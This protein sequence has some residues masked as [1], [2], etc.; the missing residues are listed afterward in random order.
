MDLPS[1][2]ICGSLNRTSFAAE[3]RSKRLACDDTACAPVKLTQSRASDKTQDFTAVFIVYL[4]QLLSFCQIDHDVPFDV[5]SARGCGRQNKAQ[6]GARQRGTL[7]VR[8]GNSSS[9]RSRRQPT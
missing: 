1:G 8:S 6:G 4:Q 5:F 7:G 3:S 9:L 2:V